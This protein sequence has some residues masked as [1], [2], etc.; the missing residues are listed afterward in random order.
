MATLLAVPVLAVGVISQFDPSLAR[1]IAG[2]HSGLP[3]KT[4]QA[5]FV[6]YAAL[7]AGWGALVLMALKTDLPPLQIIGRAAILETIFMVDCIWIRKW[8]IGVAPDPSNYIFLGIPLLMA[9]SVYL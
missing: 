1:K 2:F 9:L 4:G 5:I 8:N 3:S 7:C 6:W